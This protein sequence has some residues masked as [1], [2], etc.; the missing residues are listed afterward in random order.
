MKEMYEG[1]KESL[2]KSRKEMDDEVANMNAHSE[3]AFIRAFATVDKTKKPNMCMSCLKIE[4][5]HDGIQLSKCG[6]CK[7]V[8]Y[9]TKECITE[10]SL[11]FC[12]VQQQIFTAIFVFER[13]PH[14]KTFI[15]V[16]VCT[17]S[18]GRSIAFFCN[19]ISGHTR[20]KKAAAA[21]AMAAAAGAA[22]GV[23]SLNLEH[24]DE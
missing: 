6:R 13:S 17:H 21:A 22:E 2:S 11:F 23:A 5:R 7:Q 3:R 19:L 4:G 18:T 12:M 15:S 24:K 10:V 1:R 8:Y 9:C 16:F 20:I 14:A